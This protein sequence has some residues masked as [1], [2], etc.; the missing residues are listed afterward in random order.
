M[1]KIVFVL[2]TIFG[3]WKR[4]LETWS[5]RC[6][7][8]VNRTK[9]HCEPIWSKNVALKFCAILPFS[10]CASLAGQLFSMTRFPKDISWSNI[11]QKKRLKKQ[12]ICGNLPIGTILNCN[13]W[14]EWSMAINKC[15]NCGVQSNFGE[16]ETKK[17]IRRRSSLHSI[18]AI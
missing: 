16:T 3:G 12:Q 17:R 1:S 2:H 7:E 10:L 11:V 14:G 5:G 8:S 13:C 15:N 9:L 6:G 4:R 18:G